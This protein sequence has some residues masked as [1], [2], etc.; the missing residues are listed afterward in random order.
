MLFKNSEAENFYL[1]VV[2]CLTLHFACV[3]GPTVVDPGSGNE[4][5]GILAITAANF[6]SLITESDAVALVDFFLPTC[7]A[8][9]EMDSVVDSL[10]QR[11]SGKALVGKVNVFADSSLATLLEIYRVPTFIFFESGS[12]VR[13]MGGIIAL[14]SLAAVLDSLIGE[15]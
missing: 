8:C 1:A 3:Q 13:R 14:D 2:V 11:F 15:P 12:E 4:T 10:A 7:G 9:M 6:D 5:E